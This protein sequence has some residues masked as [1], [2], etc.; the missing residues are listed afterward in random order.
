M[1]QFR[2]NAL[3]RRLTFRLAVLVGASATAMSPVAAQTVSPSAAP[4][5]WVSY[6]EAATAAISGMLES[7]SETAT[8]FR[9]YLHQNRPENQPAPPL[10]LKVWVDDR[11]VI[12]RME[13]TP[14]A[15][16]EPNADLEKLVVGRPLPGDPPVDMLLP[17]R[18]AVQLDPPPVQ[19]LVES[20]VDGARD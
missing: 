8:R 10:V 14:F 3:I 15:H 1:N 13:F 11:R 17:M 19:V 16:P 5:E 7:D 12:S 4:V 20:S 2:F 6:A 18:I 9:A